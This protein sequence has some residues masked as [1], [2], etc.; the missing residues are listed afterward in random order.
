MSGSR[1]QLP[2]QYPRI[3]WPTLPRAAESTKRT[4]RQIVY[5]AGQRSPEAIGKL[6]L[7]IR[8]QVSAIRPG[9][10]LF[11]IPLRPRSRLRVTH[12]CKAP[13]RPLRRPYSEVANSATGRMPK[14]KFEHS[15]CITSLVLA[16]KC[17]M[18][19]WPARPNCNPS[20][21]QATKQNVTNISGVF[22]G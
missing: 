9:A 14:G 21:L 13:A 12:P 5:R 15:N 11:Q 2:T 7:T 20:S 1:S 4:G 10:F 16:E 17:K 8:C 18:A 3:I 6:R 22:N 19:G